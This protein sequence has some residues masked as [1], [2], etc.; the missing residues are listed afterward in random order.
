MLHIELICLH[1]HTPSDSV[2]AALA[3]SYTYLTHMQIWQDQRTY[4][5]ACICMHD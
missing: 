4:V 3:G 1:T 5:S 2:D